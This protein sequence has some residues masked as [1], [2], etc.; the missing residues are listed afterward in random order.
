MLTGPVARSRLPTPNP[1]MAA[2]M[3][4]RFERAATAHQKWAEPAKKAVD[5]YEGRQLTDEV[6]A[7]LLA[8]GRPALVFNVIKPLI[9][10]ALGYQRNNRT[11]TKYLPGADGSGSAELAEALTM[12]VKDAA[13]DTDMKYVDAEVFAEGML[14]GRGWY[15]VR[16]SFEHNDLGEIVARADDPFSIFVDPDATTYNPEDWNYVFETR[17]V[18]ADEIDAL[19]GKS[20]S[21][22]AGRLVG[23]GNPS[24]GLPTGMYDATEE[25]R[26]VTGFGYDGSDMGIM[27]SRLHERLFDYVDTARKS[28]RLLDC[29]HVVWGEATVFV[30][31]ETGQRVIVP[32]WMPKEKVRAIAAYNEAQGNPVRL[33]RRK[34]RR[35]R[36][37]TQIGD[38]FIHDDWSPFRTF[39]KIPFFPYF[40][41]GFTR[42]MVED[43][44]DPQ[45]EVNKRY[46]AGLNMVMRSGNTG[47]MVQKGS[48]DPDQRE[49]LE[50]QGGRAGV[51]IEYE[52]GHEKPDRIDPSPPPT[53]MERLSEQSEERLRTISG[54][55]LSATGQLDRVQSGRAIEARQRQAVLGLEPDLDNFSRTQKLKGG[56]LLVLV[57]DFYTEPRIFRVMGENGRLSMMAVNQINDI[58]GEITLNLSVGKYKVM[59]DETPISASFLQ[60]TF[61]EMLVLIEKGIPIPADFII[62]AASFGRKDELKERLA[63]MPPQPPAPQGQGAPAR[64][65]GAPAANVVPITPKGQTG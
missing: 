41:R 36:W 28:V 17:W 31:L 54:I 13:D 8:Q 38:L 22:Y 11:D 60:A 62:D 19:Y 39:T 21:T 58:T 6:R 3:L 23:G 34:V 42:G 37:T 65:R 1:K 18:S 14:T 52:Q 24:S 16:L 49:N 55:N 4:D 26:P 45:D 2:L 64:D 40:R 27:A 20:A 61:D 51:V 47:W 7:A 33:V 5:Y 9:R 46:S 12:I 59:I 15:D 43:L 53:A 63:A 25:I 50:V 48:L 30:D 57:Q 44:I 10:V 56:K 32:D 29:Q 35:V